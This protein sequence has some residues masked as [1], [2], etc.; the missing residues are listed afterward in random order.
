MGRE[1]QSVT[2]AW[3]CN[4]IKTCAGPMFKDKHEPCLPKG[5]I[6][7]SQIYFCVVYE[8]VSAPSL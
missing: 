1:G 8:Y 6:N 7:I 2:T 5:Y 3:A 4:F